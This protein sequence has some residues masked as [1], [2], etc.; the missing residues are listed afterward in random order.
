MGIG[1]KFENVQRK[2][3]LVRHDEAE[4]GVHG[5]AHKNR[6]APDFDLPEHEKEYIKDIPWRCPPAG[7]VYQ[8]DSMPPLPAMNEVMADSLK[9]DPTGSRWGRSAH[10]PLILGVGRLRFRSPAAKKEFPKS[11]HAKHTLNKRPY[12]FLRWLETRVLATDEGMHVNKENGAAPRGLN[13]EAIILE[14][15]APADGRSTRG[16][17]GTIPSATKWECILRWWS[18]PRILLP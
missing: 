15:A 9:W 12:V 5:R 17:H 2:I 6:Y 4:A 10:W 8:T 13:T 3:A 7:R 1:N 11:E 14:Q 16:Q 18:T